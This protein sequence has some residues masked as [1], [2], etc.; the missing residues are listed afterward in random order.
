MKVYKFN[1]KFREFEDDNFKAIK[2]ELIEMVYDTTGTDSNELHEKLM[3]E[4]I[5]N[6]ETN[7]DGLI[8]DSDVYEFYLRYT[9]EIDD[10]LIEKDFFDEAPIAYNITG[11]YNYLVHGTKKAVA[12]IYE[13]II[14]EN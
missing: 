1:E 3:K 2:E 14:D 11:L 7:I 8:N 4:Y 10:I 12:Y 6:Q 5:D 9:S 13:M